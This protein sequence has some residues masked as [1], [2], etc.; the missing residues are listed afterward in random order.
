MDIDHESI[1]I[2][3]KV[4]RWVSIVKALKVQVLNVNKQMSI[5]KVSKVTVEVGRHGFE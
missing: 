4:D 1:Q 5:I 2:T 3:S